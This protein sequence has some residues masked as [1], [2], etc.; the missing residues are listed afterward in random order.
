MNLPITSAP[1]PVTLQ[2]FDSFRDSNSSGTQL[3]KQQSQQLESVFISMM[4]SNLRKT[5]GEDGLF[6][7]DKS[8]TF[9]GMFDMYVADHI[10]ASGGIGLQSILQQSVLLQRTTENQGVQNLT[11]AAAAAM[12]PVLNSALDNSAAKAPRAPQPDADSSGN[13][14]GPATGFK[15]SA[16]RDAETVYR[17]NDVGFGVQTIE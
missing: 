4:I 15:G 14:S 13:V 17:R 16:Q 5:G 1:D 12:P 11:D 6:P 10:S 2:S 8:D 7:G 3:T 9:G